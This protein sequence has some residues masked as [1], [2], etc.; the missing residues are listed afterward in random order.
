MTWMYSELSWHMP[1]E[2]LG[3]AIYGRNYEKIW[4]IQELTTHGQARLVQRHVGAPAARQSVNA[5]LNP[6]NFQD[7]GAS[8]VA[9]VYWD[10]NILAYRH[11]H[12]VDYWCCETAAPRSEHFWLGETAR[13]SREST[14]LG[15][16]HN[17]LVIYPWSRFT[18]DDNSYVQLPSL[19]SPFTLNISIFPV[20]LR[21]RSGRRAR[22]PACVPPT[23]PGLQTGFMVAMISRN[24]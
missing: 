1:P 23:L 3:A 4:D 2:I 21:H 7:R 5:F 9:E 10:C 19:V 15:R 17:E 22:E 13:V 18:M 6:E 24:E 20:I 12:V 8:L 16:L 11:D 14:I